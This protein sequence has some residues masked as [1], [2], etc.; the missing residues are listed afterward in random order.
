MVLQNAAW[1]HCKTLTSQNAGLETVAKP[2]AAN[3]ILERF[4]GVAQGWRWD[5]GKGVHPSMVWPI[6]SGRQEYQHTNPIVVLGVKNPGHAQ[7][8]A[9]GE[10]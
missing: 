5:G 9:N 10:L 6:S 8:T 2:G 1:T 3:R 7:Q 4:A